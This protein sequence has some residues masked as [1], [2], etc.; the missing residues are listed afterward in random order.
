[1]ECGFSRDLFLD[2]C[3]DPKN[4][5][6]LTTRGKSNSLA[7][8][9]IAIATNSP[10]AGSRILTLEIKRRVRL[11]GAEL[12][13]FWRQKKEKE[14]QATRIRCRFVYFNVMFHQLYKRKNCRLETQRRSHRVET[15]ESSGESSD[16]DAENLAANLYPYDIMYK[17]EQQQKASCFK[18]AKK[19][20]PTFP[21]VEEKVK[22]C[23]Y[24]VGLFCFDIMII[25]HGHKG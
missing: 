21:Y 14:Q 5:I 12:D 6:I 20:Y 3:V 13:D 19:A 23:I 1:M 7:S 17:F 16:D 2:W 15:I 9:L 24:I 22:V 4:S 10:Q 25:I 18:Q 8:R 11:E